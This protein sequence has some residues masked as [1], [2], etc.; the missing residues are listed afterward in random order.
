MGLWDI[1]FMGRKANQRRRG[2]ALVELAFALPVLLGLLVGVWEIGRIIEVQ[3]AL[4]NSAEE[5][6]RQAARGLDSNA[7]VQQ[8]VI[9][10]LGS[11]GLPTTNVSVSVSDRT[12]PGTDVR[13]ASRLDELQVSV[14]IPYG[15]VRWLPLDWFFGAASLL[16]AQSIWYSARVDAYPADISVPPGY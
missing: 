9:N 2:A 4:G 10:Y 14:T 15:D 8:V 1:A 6:A 13:N 5:G 12:S 11:A 7:Q 3:Q 16:R